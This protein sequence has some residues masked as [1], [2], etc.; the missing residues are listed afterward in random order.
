MIHGRQFTR[1]YS[2]LIRYGEDDPIELSIEL[3]CAFD[4]NED[5]TCF[6]LRQTSQIVSFL[7]TSFG[8]PSTIP[9]LAFVD[10]FEVEMAHPLVP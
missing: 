2:V 5:L 8:S 6:S 4:L 1:R 10:C 7:N 9:S 3:E